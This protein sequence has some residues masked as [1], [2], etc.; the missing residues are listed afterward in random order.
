MVGLLGDGFMQWALLVLLYRRAFARRDWPL[1]LTRYALAGSS[2]I[3]SLDLPS[4]S[5]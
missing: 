2:V 5:E 1:G 4:Q 3:S